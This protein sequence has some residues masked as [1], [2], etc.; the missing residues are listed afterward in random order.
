[1]KKEKRWV[2]FGG[3]MWEEKGAFTSKTSAL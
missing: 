2:A 1:V 3:R